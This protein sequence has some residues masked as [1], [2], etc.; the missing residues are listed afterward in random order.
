[1]HNLPTDS[2]GYES[3]MSDSDYEGMIMLFTVIVIH[4][5]RAEVTATNQNNT[6]QAGRR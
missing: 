4:T 6:S 5:L 3:S 2:S 1:M